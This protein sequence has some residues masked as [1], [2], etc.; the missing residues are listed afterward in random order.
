MSIWM[1]GDLQGCCA[2]LES[3][4]ARPE[5]A[6]DADAHFWFAGDLVNRGPASL[7]TIRRVMALGE[8]AVAVLGNHDLHLLA[9]AAGVR[10]P[11]KSDT[12]Q[13]ILDAPDAAEILRW[14]R[15]RPLA[16]YQHGHLLVH[17]GVLPGWTA[18]QTLA[19]AGEVEAALRGP[20]WKGFLTRMYGNLPAAWDDSLQGA[21]RLR[22]I[23]N[24]L[25]RMRF[26][27]ADGTMEFAAKDGANHAPPGFMPWFDVPSR[28][29][30]S[31]T[32]VFGHWS[33]LGLLERPGLLALDTGCVW[34]GHLT[35]A[36]LED[37][38]L[39]QV[40]CQQYRAPG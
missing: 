33:T 29:T 24:A 27:T 10:K 13:D 23:V 15:H 38:K 1:I 37:H 39:V 5:I 26:C 16:H 36:R 21:D 2:P 19:L 14:L 9:V 11:G 8:R 40:R 7:A 30:E 3:L 34:G 18:A 22:V 31:V 12:I 35:A 20:D 28:A 6:G 17:A 25:T 4:L 32:V